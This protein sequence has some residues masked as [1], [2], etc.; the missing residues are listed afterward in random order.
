MKKKGLIRRRLVRPADAFLPAGLLVTALAGRAELSLCVWLSL[1]AVRMVGLSTATGVRAAFAVQPS[2][3]QVI[4]SVRAAV[5]AQILSAV[6]C[7]GAGFA[8]FHGRAFPFPI[9]PI[10]IGML[11]N[12]EHVF[13]EYLY[14]EGDGRSA[15][16][17]RFITA[18][19]VSAGIALDAG[20]AFTALPVWTCGAAAVSSLV[21]VTIALSAGVGSKGRLN[22]GILRAA[23]RA[24]L[25]TLFY[26]AAGC[27]YMYFSGTAS[28]C[29]PPFFAGLLIYELCR[30][31]FRRSAME[32]KGLNRALLIVCGA[33]LVL[34]AVSR[35]PIAGALPAALRSVSGMLSGT[36]LMLVISAACAFAMF[37]NIRKREN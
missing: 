10:L 7:A 35:L 33:A 3:R 11:L 1:F 37:G 9:A 23:P 27:A 17:S 26:P 5:I 36:A 29:I 24:M 21:S 30:T 4:G 20:A 31:P 34:F 2:M 14:A 18:I 12:I 32:S 15:T 8:L 19:L 16:L 13:Y 25:Y 6:I 28:E 22:A